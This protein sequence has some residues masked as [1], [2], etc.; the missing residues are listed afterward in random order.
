VEEDARAWLIARIELAAQDLKNAERHRRDM[1]FGRLLGFLE[2]GT[3][4]GW[5]T[6]RSAD[7]FSDAAWHGVATGKASRLLRKR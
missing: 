5:W 2:V 6:K 7:C 3:R 4:F 1:R